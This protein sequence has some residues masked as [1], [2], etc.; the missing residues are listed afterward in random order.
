M[1]NRVGKRW[2]LENIYNNTEIHNYLNMTQ[3]KQAFD[4]FSS[5]FLKEFAIETLTEVS[6]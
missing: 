3:N 5:F 2:A 6:Q 1:V 4:S